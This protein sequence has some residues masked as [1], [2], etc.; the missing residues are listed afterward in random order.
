ML[1]DSKADY[2]VA[3]AGSVPLTKLLNQYSGL[4]Q[5]IWVAELSSRHMDWNEVPEGVG[6]KAEIA[7]WHEIIDE[8]TATNS[9]ELPSSI[10]DDS[11]PHIVIVTETPG[12]IGFS[13]VTFAQSVSQYTVARLIL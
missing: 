2:L 10:E 7:V 5:V 3:S 13:T 12:E 11:L 9:S 8:K 4:R 1:D 6:G